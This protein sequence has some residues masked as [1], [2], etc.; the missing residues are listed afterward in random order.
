MGIQKKPYIG[1]MSALLFRYSIG[2]KLAIYLLGAVTLVGIISCGEG[3]DDDIGCGNGPI[4]T[5]SGS[6]SDCESNGFIDVLVEG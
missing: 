6:P 3:S 1:A 5:L 4:L 2:L